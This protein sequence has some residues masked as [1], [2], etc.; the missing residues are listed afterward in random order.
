MFYTTLVLRWLLYAKT[1]RK[2]VQ[3]PDGIGSGSQ[4]RIVDPDRIGSRLYLGL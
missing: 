1:K 2:T 4:D 3:L